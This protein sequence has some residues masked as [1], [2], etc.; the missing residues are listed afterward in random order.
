MLVN[1]DKTEELRYYVS[2]SIYSECF[3]IILIIVKL[4]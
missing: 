1:L 3:H 2:K 4:K